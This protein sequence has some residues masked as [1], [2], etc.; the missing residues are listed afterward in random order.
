MNSWSGP[1]EGLT[2]QRAIRALENYGYHAEVSEL[3]RLLLKAISRNFSFPQQWNPKVRSADIYH[4]REHAES[5]SYRQ[6]G[7]S[8]LAPRRLSGVRGHSGGRGWAGGLL[9]PGVAL[10]AGVHHHGPWNQAQAR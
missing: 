1:V 6:G 7:I 10:G 9:R 5:V 3:G 8:R 2:Y 4:D